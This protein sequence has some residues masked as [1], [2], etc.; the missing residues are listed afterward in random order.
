MTRSWENV[1]EFKKTLHD[2]LQQ[3]KLTSERFV[4]GTKEEVDTTVQGT[5]IK[6]P[7]HSLL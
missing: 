6:G 1:K 5:G 2:T 4:V 7:H 3:K